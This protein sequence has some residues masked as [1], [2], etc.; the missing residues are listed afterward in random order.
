MTPEETSPE[1]KQSGPR[2]I[3]WTA[4]PVGT[5]LSSQQRAPLSG[6]YESETREPSEL[7][8]QVAAKVREALRNRPNLR[9]RRLEVDVEAVDDQPG[10]IMFK[11]EVMG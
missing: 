8:R 7:A 9:G 2:R 11:I 5:S 4:R 10:S 3:R 6:E 1:A